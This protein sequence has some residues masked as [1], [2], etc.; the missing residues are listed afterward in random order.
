MVYA[1]ELK[2][3]GG[4]VDTHNKH[5]CRIAHVFRNSLRRA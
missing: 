2:S 5:I 4:A 1:D 3:R